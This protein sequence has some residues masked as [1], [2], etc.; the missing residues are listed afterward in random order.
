MLLCVSLW[1]QKSSVER[2]DRQI[3]GSISRLGYHL[4]R[5]RG[6]HNFSE[7]APIPGPGEAVGDTANA[8]VLR[9]LCG[10]R[11][12]N[13]DRGGAAGALAILPAGAQL[14]PLAVLGVA[15]VARLLPATLGMEESI[16]VE[17]DLLMNVLPAEDAT[18]LST[19][20][21]ANKETERG[22]ASRCSAHG[23]GTIRLNVCVSFIGR[24]SDK[25]S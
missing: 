23:S 20:M 17:P 7:S 6:G 11:G 4:L 1:A 2:P 16:L 24:P 5:E 18:T 19:V 22:L 15:T 10:G 3:Y 8:V 12:V 21:A 14:L 9:S 25:N 13:L